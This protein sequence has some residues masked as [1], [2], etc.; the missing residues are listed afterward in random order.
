MADRFRTHVRVPC[1]A[2]NIDT[3][4]HGT[5]GLLLDSHPGK[6]CRASSRTSTIAALTS[7]GLATQLGG[8]LGVS[9]GAVRTDQP[10]I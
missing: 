3:A 7:D 6:G 8:L 5:L 9:H 10:L 4:R 1:T 2:V